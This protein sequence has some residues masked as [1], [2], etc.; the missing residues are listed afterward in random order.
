VVREMHR[1][2]INKVASAKSKW[3]T[4]HKKTR[5]L[6][7]LM[8]CATGAALGP[9]LPTKMPGELTSGQM[10]PHDALRCYRC[11]PGE[12]LERAGWIKQDD[13]LF[14]TAQFA[15]V[16]VNTRLRIY[17]AGVRDP[18]ELQQVGTSWRIFQ[19]QPANSL[20]PSNVSQRKNR[21]VFRSDSCIRFYW[22]RASSYSALQSH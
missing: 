4:A 14:L 8:L 13:M 22:A 2:S 15:D 1:K 19:T 3:S 10:T 9:L 17:L 11:P 21:V 7:V 5:L 12:Q 18:L 16:P 20:I 6:L